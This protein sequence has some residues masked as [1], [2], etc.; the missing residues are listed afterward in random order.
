VNKQDSL[1]W[2]QAVEQA[3]ADKK[4]LE[5]R[6]LDVREVFPLADYF[7]IAQG[8]SYRH[9]MTLCDTCIDLARAHKVPH[10]VQG[11]DQG[12]SWIALDLCSVFVHLFLEDVRKEVGLE[13]LWA[14]LISQKPPL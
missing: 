8:S 6:F 2:R 1:I 14:P 4:A 3:L 13:E 12:T 11:R 5:V 9:L 10:T 7:V